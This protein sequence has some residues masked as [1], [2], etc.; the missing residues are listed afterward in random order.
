MPP[1]A[2]ISTYPTKI[3]MTEPEPPL[4]PLRQA[5]TAPATTTDEMASD[6]VPQPAADVLH[7][8]NSL[9]SLVSVTCSRSRSKGLLFLCI[10]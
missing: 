10:K 2:N 4:H 9:S 7:P 3:T 1:E 8:L 5:A 6:S